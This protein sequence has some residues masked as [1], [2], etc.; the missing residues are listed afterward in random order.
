MIYKALVQ[1]LGW[2]LNAVSA[3]LGNMEWESGYNPWRW[4]WDE[5]LPSTDYRKEDIGYGLVQFTP[6]QKYIDAEIAKSSPGYAP[7][8]SDVMGSPDDGTAQCYF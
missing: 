2:T 1:S 7:H 8:F 6:P 3:V 5:P 4:G